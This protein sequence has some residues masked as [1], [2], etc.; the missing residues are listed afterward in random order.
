MKIEDA[1]D[2]A[3][4]RF[5]QALVS[6]C[7]SCE[8]SP[9]CQFLPLHT[10]PMRTLRDLD[11]ARYMLNFDG[12]ELGVTPD[13]TWQVYLHRPCRHLDLDTMRCRVHGTDRQPHVCKQYPAH[14]CWYRHALQPQG[15][16]D[17]LRVDRRRL[18]HVLDH[19][20]FD[21]DRRI[22][23]APSWDALTSAFAEL[24][25][26]SPARNDPP[27][28]G[29]AGTTETVGG[30]PASEP[31]DLAFGDPQV[32]DPCSACAAHC[33]QSLLFPLPTP[34]DAA[35]VDH[36]RF[37]LGFPGVEVA[38]S[39]DQ[40]GLVVHATCRHLDGTRCGVFGTPERPVRC[41]D[42]DAWSCLYRTVFE[43]AIYTLVDLAGF[44]DLTDG[45]TF[46]RWG[47]AS[48]P[49][50]APRHGGARWGNGLAVV[51]RRLPMVATAREPAPPTVP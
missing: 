19:V 47:R 5:D 28:A 39:S 2:E 46:D 36:V 25:L 34:T 16:E 45:V 21:E 48:P 11:Y 26:A 18:D 20:R 37:C 42:L 49:S 31:A 27:S 24:P 32:Q 17:H 35:A 13:G 6:P 23:A 40:W 51:G 15:D 22:V 7:L 41:S 44:D 50:S 30:P 43:G 38:V 9:C 8:T 4:L 29:R 1:V 14:A 33:C 3:R 10:F 12:I